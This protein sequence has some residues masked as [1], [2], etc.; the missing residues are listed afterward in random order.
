MKVLITGPVPIW[1]T[2]KLE[3]NN[4]TVD[5]CTSSEL[6]NEEKFINIISKYDIYIS[7]GLETCS[8]AVIEA[9]ENLKAI[10][11]LGTDCSIYI[12]TKT[13]K[14]KNI[15]IFCTPGANANAVAE[16][17]ILNILM[18][19]RKMP[20]MLKNMDSNIWGNETGTELKGKN[21]GVIGA[22]NIAQKVANIATNLGMTVSYWNQSG[23][24]NAME[25]DFISIDNLLK[26]SDII[27]FHIPEKS[28]EILTLDR[29]RKVKN[30]V[31]I[32]NTSPAKLVNADALYSFLKQNHTASAIFD[33]FYSEGANAWKCPESKLFNLSPHQFN[34]TPHTG[35]RT[36][37][38]DSNMF[39]VII[40]H[41]MDLTS[42]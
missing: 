25:G 39:T 2:K 5:I 11:F 30:N 37:E 29:F 32:V 16:L 38:A 6:V 12:D 20:L 27:T 14:E 22:G 23:A 35:W 8:K 3:S 13:A 41:L 1:V 21:L 26:K 9:A 40:K 10:M 17:T 28:G 4:F 15:P 19:A 31:I 34:V 33:T 42:R 24:K 36:M 18:M 7:G